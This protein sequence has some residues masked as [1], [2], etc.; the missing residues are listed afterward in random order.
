MNYNIFYSNTE[1]N[2]H[3]KAKMQ[4]FDYILQGKIKIK[5][6]HNNTYNIFQGEYDT[7]F[8]H[9][10]SFI[11]KP[12]QCKTYINS[13][14]FSNPDL[15]CVKYFNFN[16]KEHRLLC[17]Q[18]S[19]YGAIENIPCR[20]CIE[21]NLG[22]N[23]DYKNHFIGFTPDIAFG[24]NGEHKV[25]L[26][27]NYTHP[28]SDGKINYCKNNNITLLEIDVNDISKINNKELIFYNYN[29][30][31]IIVK[32]EFNDQIAND[33]I[34]YYIKGIKNKYG[35]KKEIRD[36]FIDY[37]SY[38]NYED[39]YLKFLDDNNFKEYIHYNTFIK[40][41][42]GIEISGFPHLIVS[43]ELYN[44]LINLEKQETEVKKFK[45]SILEDKILQ[46]IDINNYIVS[47]NYKKEYNKLT[48]NN[49]NVWVNFLTRNNL[50]E[51]IQ[52]TRELK[53]QLGITSKGYPYLL[54]KNIA[55]C[56]GG[57]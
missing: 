26:E 47:N 12:I 8:L 25:W 9:I 37:Y 50:K 36:F 44:I 57:E 15:P 51:I 14:M 34:D 23:K 19:Y 6:N 18:K 28:C 41:Y 7:E 17:D 30:S 29:L 20:K 1:S 43:K 11:V 45:L 40:S 22:N 53:E 31:Y 16:K 4:L 46:D 33:I 48:D 49:Y 10:E 55:D 3:Y 52:Y 13:V 32:N 35:M 42:L 38:F 27:I 56:K 21:I 39:K 24:Y 54:T 2:T 5:D